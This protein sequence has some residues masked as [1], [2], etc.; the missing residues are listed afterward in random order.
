MHVAAYPG[1]ESGPGFLGAALIRDRVL[2]LS[3]VPQPSP[4]ED[5]HV[6]S[7]SRD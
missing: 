4:K 5:A 1:D 6:R 3:G 7:T 2:A